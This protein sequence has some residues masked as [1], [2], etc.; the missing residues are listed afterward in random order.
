MVINFKTKYNTLLESLRGGFQIGDEVIITNPFES[1]ENLYNRRWL[2]RNI[3]QPGKIVGFRS[4]VRAVITFTNKKGKE[5]RVNCPIIFLRKKSDIAQ[6]SNN[7]DTINSTNFTN[8]INQ[9]VKMIEYW[10]DD[11]RITE[12]EFLALTKT[13]PENREDMKDLL[14]I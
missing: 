4:S 7:P 9:Y 13:K 14:D 1:E 5:Q 6:T 11:K 3:G 10:I 8:L 2:L 12:N